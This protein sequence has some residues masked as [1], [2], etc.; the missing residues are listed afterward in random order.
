[1]KHHF[2]DMI[3][4]E[5][6]HWTTIPN[7]ERYIFSISDV[8]PG[9]RDVTIVTIGKR[10]EAWERV[11]TLPN[12]EEVTLHEPTPKQLAA[13]S[14]LRSLK[15]LR[16]THARTK[17]I[18]FIRPL[19]NVE[20]LVLEYVSG[21]EDLAPLQDLT[22]LRAVHFE[23]LRKVVDFGGLSGISSLKYLAIYG[24][25]D[26]KQPIADFEFLNGLPSL[27][28]LGLWQFITRQPFP[29][30][31]PIRRL[32]QLK[33]LNLHG[34]YLNTDEYALMEEC[35]KGR[36]VKGSQWGPYRKTAYRQIPLPSNDIRSHLSDDV[37]RA[38]HPEVVLRFDG[39]REIGDPD[40]EWFEFTGKAAGR[41][42][43]DHPAASAKCMEIER[44]Y[45][46]MKRSAREL[47]ERTA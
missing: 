12:L 29:A 37:I 19:H 20:E 2:G 5:S 42:K 10:D 1:M 13:I 21:F 11:F 40:S 46:A 47:I 23:N 8:I 44:K 43:C 30:M 28:Y 7:V 9:S 36:G 18:D 32:T 16:I 34:S 26:W 27:E 39:K 38:E 33:K 45:E 24:T 15:R 31:L 17:S 41:A 35:L 25:L 14:E 6:G 3:D 22:R 4:R